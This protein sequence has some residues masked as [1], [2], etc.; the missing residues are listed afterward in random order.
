MGSRNAGDRNSRRPATTRPGYSRPAARPT[1]PRQRSYRSTGP[2][3]T[4]SLD[5][6]QLKNYATWVVFVSFVIGCMAVMIT[7]DGS[8]MLG[9]IV[10]GLFLGY[11]LY[12][13]I[14]N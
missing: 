12:L 4:R 6:E 10:L 9:T 13:G 7:G 1:K 14:Y 3:Y 5:P 11:I 8:I 2:S